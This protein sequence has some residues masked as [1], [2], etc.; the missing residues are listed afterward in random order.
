MD[1]SS[2]EPQKGFYVTNKNLPDQDRTDYWREAVSP[3]YEALEASGEHAVPI[4]GSIRSL[5]LGER[6]IAEATFG[7][8]RCLRTAEW[9]RRSHFDYYYIQ[10]FVSGCCYGSFQGKESI[11]S[12]GD[13]HI[14]SVT[15][16]VDAICSSSAATISLVLEKEELE[17]IC[18]KSNLNGTIIRAD[19]ALGKLLGG[20][21][22]SFYSEAENLSFTE[23]VACGDVLLNLLASAVKYDPD[24]IHSAPSEQLRNQVLVFI[25]QNINDPKLGIEQILERFAISRSYLYRLL[26]ADGGAAGLIRKKRLQ[27]AHSELMRRRDE[28]SLRIKAIAYK[29][30]F[31]N[32][33]QFARS[34][35]KQFSLSPSEFLKRQSMTERQ[36][37]QIIKL[38]SYYDNFSETDRGK[39]AL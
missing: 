14:A 17:Y 26:E 37:G 18:G 20:F 29:Y 7:N 12:A 39:L 10:L 13:I 31:S 19:T 22:R 25:N 4:H 30:G 27:L 21:F 28:S 35:Q 5:P 9:I 6:F 15:A 11:I 23:G 3:L 38:Q 1:L 34:F 36:A 33:V 8:H 16:D 2:K 32:T 24:N